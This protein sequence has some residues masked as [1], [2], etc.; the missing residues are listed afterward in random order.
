MK[1]E[2]EART[3]ELRNTLVM[4][5]SGIVDWKNTANW[6]RVE[7]LAQSL[8]VTDEEGELHDWARIWSNVPDYIRKIPPL[9]AV[10]E[11][12]AILKQH[13]GDQGRIQVAHDRYIVDAESGEILGEKTIPPRKPH[14]GIPRKVKGVWAAHIPPQQGEPPQ[15]GDQVVVITRKGRTTNR[16]IATIIGK[17]PNGG[18]NVTIQ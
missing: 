1:P 8:T 18:H 13:L 17:T 2:E 9:G 12:E 10:R 4:I 14:R 7:N 5:M 16:I 11:L 15:P 3:Q 6:E